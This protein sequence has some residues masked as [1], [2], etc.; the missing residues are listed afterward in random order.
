MRA[1][2]R[3]RQGLS[4]LPSIT[5]AFRIEAGHVLVLLALLLLTLV[6]L[7]A[8]EAFPLQRYSAHVV[9]ISTGVAMMAPVL[10]VSDRFLTTIA[11]TSRVMSRHGEEHVALWMAIWRFTFIPLVFL[12]AVFM[13][14]DLFYFATRHPLETC[15]F[16]LALF[17]VGCTVLPWRK[18]SDAVSLIS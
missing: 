9:L 17:A 15:A 6:V 13:R 5:M 18:R 11:G 14:R 3:L 2:N 16:C 8:A 7:A 10:M 1:I 12:A 4:H